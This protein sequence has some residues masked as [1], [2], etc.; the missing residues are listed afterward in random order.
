M[1]NYADAIRRREKAKEDA[2]F[3]KKEQELIERLRQRKQVD[4]QPAHP[5]SKPD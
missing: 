4:E 2:Y 5:Q 1:A 3:A